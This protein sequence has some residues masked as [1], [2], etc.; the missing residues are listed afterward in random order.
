MAEVLESVP[1]DDPSWRPVSYLKSKAL[2]DADKGSGFAMQWLTPQAQKV[3]TLRKGYH[4][5]G[6]TDPRLRHP[7]D[8]QLSRLLT[9]GEHARIKGIPEALLQGLSATAAHQACGQSVDARVVQ[10]IG[11]WLGQGLR[12]MR[13]PLPGESATVKPSTLAA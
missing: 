1:L 10:A 4:K 11:R 13:R 6:S 2:R 3:P 5:G 7:H 8:E 12:A 9:P